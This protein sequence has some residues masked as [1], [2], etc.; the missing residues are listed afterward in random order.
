VHAL[1]P[2]HSKSVLGA[3]VLGSGL[4]AARALATA[5]VL[6]LTHISSAIVLALVAN[7]LV[8]RTIVG[9]GQA[10]ALELASRLLLIAIGAWLIARALRHRPHVH[11]EGL[12]VGIIAGLVPCPLTLFTMTYAV[13]RGVPEAGLAFALAMLAILELDR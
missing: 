2:G 9:A 7:A 11:G 5:F 4:S 3:Y 6:A 13:A 10:P 12:A 1:T 8:T